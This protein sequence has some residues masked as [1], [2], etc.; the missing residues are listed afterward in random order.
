LGPD[1]QLQQLG[2][3][4][5]SGGGNVVT[6][7]LE[8]PRIGTDL[9]ELGMVM[10]RAVS[11]RGQLS[12]WS[13][14]R[15]Q[16]PQPYERAVASWNVFAQYTRVVYDELNREQDRDC[17]VHVIPPSWALPV[18]EDPWIEVGFTPTEG[19]RQYKLYYRI[20]NGPLTLAREQSGDFNLL[21]ALSVLLEVMPA[22]AADV[23]LFLQTFDLN[24]NPSR[25]QRL[26]CV[27]VEG[28]EPLPTPML[29]P[30]VSS[31]DGTTPTATLTWFCP[32]HGLDRFRVWIASTPTPLPADAS[33]LLYVDSSAPIPNEKDEQ[34]GAE[35]RTFDY[36]SFNTELIGPL[37][38]NGAEFSLSFPVMMGSS[39]RVKVAAVTADGTVGPWSNAVD[40]SWTPD[41]GFTGPD[42]PWPARPMTSYAGATSFHPEL[43]TVYLPE[44]QTAGVRIGKFEG[45]VE[46]LFDEKERKW[47]YW[48]FRDGRPEDSLFT[49]TF[50]S[51]AQERTVLPAILYRTQLADGTN[52][53]EVPGDV[54]QV[55]PLMEHIITEPL[56]GSYRVHDP[57][58]HIAVD[59][60]NQR[61]QA[62]YLVDTQP[63]AV[64]ASYTYL[65]VLFDPETMEPLQILPTGT[66]TIP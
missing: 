59:P 24:G 49:S 40:Y 26:A 28:S 43:Q 23:C 14:Q 11:S 38:G 5:F 16:V 25:M 65:L 13:S 19:T 8:I 64:G 6:K 50:G 41:A 21:V 63:Q 4:H 37:F 20:D 44:R 61:F 33:D 18:G 39:M 17:S 9:K 54:V 47:V 45:P 12:G 7:D 31:T 15:I 22:S 10:A 30:V 52:Y 46:V 62:I 66:I 55:S 32:P 48:V 53:T 58:I 3:V 2:R 35:L 1:E 51:P 60:R 27:P 56:S 42:V 34:V 57:F 36:R 29:A